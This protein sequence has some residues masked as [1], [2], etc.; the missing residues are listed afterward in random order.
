MVEKLTLFAG[1][2]NA[3]LQKLLTTIS[4]YLAMVKKSTG[5]NLSLTLVS[6]PLITKF[7]ISRWALGVVLFE[8]LC[9]CLPFGSNSTQETNRLF[10]KILSQEI[11]F[12][13]APRGTSKELKRLISSLLQKG[14]FRK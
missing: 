4:T 8:M 9:G 10:M 7:C 11:D 5:K 6:Y 12:R 3:W 14:K 1:P 2:P 13:M